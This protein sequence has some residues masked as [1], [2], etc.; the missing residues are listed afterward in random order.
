MLSTAYVM[1]R[2]PWQLRPSLQLIDLAVI[3]EPN[4][5]GLVFGP[6]G[7]FWIDPAEV[8]WIGAARTHICRKRP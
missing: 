7:P 2:E 3:G 1:A 8:Y 4:S 5:Q 6:R